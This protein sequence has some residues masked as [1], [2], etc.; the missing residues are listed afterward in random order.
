MTDT[1]D[2]APTTAVE[3]AEL[4]LCCADL[5]L[6]ALRTYYSDCR[7]VSRGV[8][9]ADTEALEDLTGSGELLANLCRPLDVDPETVAELMLEALDAGRRW[10]LE[11]TLAM[12]KPDSDISVTRP[13]SDT[14]KTKT[15]TA[16]VG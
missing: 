2:T 12:K 5:W 14:Q 11:A 3:L 8:V 7:S 13:V 4:A 15:A 6:S 10:T 9:T 1:A 16:D